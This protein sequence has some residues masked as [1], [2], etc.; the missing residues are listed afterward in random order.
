VT[1]QIFV[2]FDRPISYQAEGADL[3]FSAVKAPARLTAGPITS[4]YTVQPATD[5]SAA[6]CLFVLKKVSIKP[7]DR[8]VIVKEKILALEHE[9]EALRNFETHSNIAKVLD[10]RIDPVDD[11]WHV[12]VLMDYARKGSLTEMLSTFDSLPA[13]R[14]R[15]WTIELLEAL[16]FYHRQGIIHKRIHPG[17]VL[18]CQST[19]G[20]PMHT[21]LADASFQ[22]SLHDLQERKSTSIFSARSSYWSPPE[23]TEHKSRKTDVWDLGVIFIQMLFGL[24]TP[25]KHSGPT[26]LID[27]MQLTTP[28]EGI[29]RKFFKP[30]PK[31]RPSAFD[32]IPSEF[33]RNDVDVYSRPTS[34]AHSRLPSSV[35]LPRPDRRALRR[36]SSAFMV[37]GTFSRF[38]SEWVEVGRLG[39]GG[40]GEVVKARNKLDGQVYAIK[41]IKQNS[42]PALDEVLSEVMLLSRL[43]HPYVVR[44]YTAWPEDDFS[45]EQ[46][47]TDEGT[48]TATETETETEEAVSFSIGELGKSIDFGHSTTGGL[49]HISFSGLGA[50]IQFGDDS[51]DE[52]DEDTRYVGHPLPLKG[53]IL[54]V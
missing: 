18:L 14:T 49:D 19:P 29:I 52:I 26:S 15:T 53:G 21:K 43:N 4:I 41:R 33:L 50:D 16:D 12:S 9:L 17:N 37:T 27:R 25:Q 35:S 40:Y 7:S 23:G 1:E 2:S 8:Q 6:S 54:L 34:P 38:A 20:S 45:E 42:A 31:K 36:G 28:L 13:A 30:D 10:F 22:D 11:T 39:K 44:Y 46:S 5:A 3:E 24:H 51:E 32:L 48:E 47:G